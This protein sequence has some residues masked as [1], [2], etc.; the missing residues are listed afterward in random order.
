[1]RWGTRTSSARTG[2]QNFS[3]GS[4]TLIRTRRARARARTRVMAVGQ[5]TGRPLA[6]DHS[7]GAKS[8]FKL[9]L[10]SSTTGE[11]A[12]VAVAGVAG[13]RSLLGELVTNFLWDLAPVLG[14]DARA[15]RPALLTVL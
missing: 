15:G 9:G 5:Q 11:E 14:R 8:L 3:S 1:M 2:A 10:F 12:G 6:P 13:V 4:A 7:A